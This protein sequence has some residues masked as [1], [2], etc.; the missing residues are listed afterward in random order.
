MDNGFKGEVWREII[1]EFNKGVIEEKK[2]VQQLKN[3]VN[4][5][6]RFLILFLLKN[7]DKYKLI[8]NIYYNSLKKSGRHLPIC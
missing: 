6:R 7:K 8:W 4:T 2:T 3:R 1:E 5:V